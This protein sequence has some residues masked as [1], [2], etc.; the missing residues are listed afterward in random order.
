MI[1]ALGGDECMNESGDSILTTIKKLLGID[2]DYTVFDT[3]I[4]IH[5]NSV[6]SILQEIGVGP[7]GGF[8]I[9]DASENW[10]DYIQDSNLLEQVKT[11]VYLKVRLIF[12]PPQTSPLIDAINRTIS[13]LE[14]R[15]SV[16]VSKPN[17]FGGE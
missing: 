2:K 8:K 6:F 11:Y 14:W 17:G 10:S 15:L 9:H 7:D 12:D 3:D 16:T 13:E 4:I 1:L 5:I